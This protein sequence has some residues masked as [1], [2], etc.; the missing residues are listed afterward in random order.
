MR[1]KWAKHIGSSLIHNHASLGLSF[2]KGNTHFYKYSM[3]GHIYL[4]L[5]ILLEETVANTNWNG[6]SIH[7]TALEDKLSK[8][9]I[10]SQIPLFAGEISALQLASSAR[11]GIEKLKNDYKICCFYNIIEWRSTREDVTSMRMQQPKIEDYKILINDSNIFLPEITK[12]MNH[13]C[14]DLSRPLAQMLRLKTKNEDNISPNASDANTRLFDYE[15]IGLATQHDL[16]IFVSIDGSLDENDIA[17]VSISMIDHDIHEV[18]NAKSENWQN[19]M[20]R[21]LLIRSW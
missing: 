14:E 12:S 8:P 10:C 6:N 17:T 13:N 5:G 15:I 3:L 20:A 4:F 7:S 16:P 1:D 2:G 11:I 9:A 19:R 18:D 21:A